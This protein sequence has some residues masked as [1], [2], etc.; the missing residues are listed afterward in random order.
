[1][2]ISSI[3]KE[4]LEIAHDRTMLGVLLI[5]PVFIMLFMGS[6]F[7]SIEISGLPVGVVGPT[8]TAFSSVLFGGLNES[9]AFKLQNFE[10]QES[11]MESFRNGQLRAIIVVPADIDQQLRNGDGTEIKIIVDNSDI[12]LQKAIVAAMSSVMQASSTNITRSYVSEAWNDLGEL[13][14]SA[15]NLALSINE[16]K[17]SMIR[18]KQNLEN[19]RANID[20]LEIGSLE[21]SL[22]NTSL[23][24][25][26]LSEFAAGETIGNDSWKFL[27]DAEF[28]LNESIHTVGDTHTK[29]NDQ[30]DGLEKTAE[31]LELSV[32]ALKIAKN[33]TT[34]PI[35]AAVLDANIA[36]LDSLKNSTKQQMADAEQQ[37]AELESLNMTLHEFSISLD[38]YSELVSQAEL[39]QNTK[40]EE[41]QE[42]IS[43]LDVSLGKAESTIKKMK[44]LFAQ[45]DTTTNDIEKT[46]DEVLVQIGNVDD[47]IGSLQ[48][49]VAEQTAKNPERIASPLSVVVQDHYARSSFVDFI[50]PQVI[51]VSLLFS[52][53]L[54]ASISLVREKTRKTVVRLLLIPG[55]FENSIIAKIATIT[56]ISLG[57]V[58]IIL[59]VG[60]SIFSVQAPANAIMLVIG[61]AISALVLSAI[62]ILLGFFARTESAAIQSS[63][64]I[65]IP[66]L[67]L[68]NIMF[69]PDLLPA[70]TQILQQLLPLAHI[71]NIFK[72]VLITNGD[73]T[74]NILALVSYFVLLAVIVAF[75][76]IR[77]RDISQY[78]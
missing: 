23:Q 3:K 70:Y 16:S 18:T 68:G 63:L 17:G 54:L 28:A 19:I 43:R 36:A 11:A 49:T 37:L 76:M 74:A 67:F 14:K 31:D 66:M 25:S 27:E 2:I 21:E 61:T 62:G 56:L 24:I 35:T 4:F 48:E 32:S 30:I 64:L 45:I 42:K 52:C 44:D 69:S 41:F 13:D 7:G 53:F 12:A 78:A 5:F 72:I 47:L 29:I 71:T 6:S 57:Q 1:M 34:D 22:H 60:I 50:I 38:E 40:I 58:A 46:L 77:R 33:T 65:A 9:T 20:D 10:T 75:I 73:P 8:N 26:S 15:A 55:A 51:A 39:E 59:L